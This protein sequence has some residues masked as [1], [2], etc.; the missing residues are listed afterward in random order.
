MKQRVALA[1]ALAL[2]PDILLMD[3]PFG[4][5]DPKS[6]DALQMELVDIWQRTRQDDRLRHA[7]HGRGGASRLAR[8]RAARASGARGARRERGVDVAAAAA[9]RSG[10]GAWSWRRGSR[11]GS[12]RRASTRRTMA[13]DDARTTATTADGR[14]E[15]P[16]VLALGL[17]L[18]GWACLSRFGPWPAYLL[19]GPGGVLCARSATPCATASWCARWRR[20]SIGSSS[21]TRCRRARGSRSA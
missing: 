6:R 17:L 19:P 7:R 21:A 4:A 2:E 8:D 16:A 15:L 11:A 9:R 20:R 1:R 3:E 5:L 13:M 10:G 14:P 12:T 18:L